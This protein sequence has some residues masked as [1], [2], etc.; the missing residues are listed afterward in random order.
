MYSYRIMVLDKGEIREFA[1]P[2]ELLKNQ[3]GIFHS[4]VQ[5]AGLITTITEDAESMETSSTNSDVTEDNDNT[6]F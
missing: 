4:M 6:S 3:N 1:S 5:D 2:T